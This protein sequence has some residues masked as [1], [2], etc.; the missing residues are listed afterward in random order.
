MNLKRAL[1]FTRISELPK[2]TALTALRN[3]EDAEAKADEQKAHER[4]HDP[5]VSE[6]GSAADGSRHPP[7]EDDDPDS[8]AAFVLVTSPSTTMK[9]SR[10]HDR[11]GNGDWY[12]TQHD[13][14]SLKH[15]A[16]QVRLDPPS[17]SDFA[18]SPPDLDAYSSEVSPSPSPLP[19]PIL[20][21]TSSPQLPESPE[22]L[23]DYDD[24]TTDEE[25]DDEGFGSDDSDPEDE[26]GGMAIRTPHLSSK[27]R[28][29]TSTSSSSNNRIRGDSGRVISANRRKGSNGIL[30]SLVGGGSRGIAR[31]A[32]TGTAQASTHSRVRQVRTTGTTALSSSRGGSSNK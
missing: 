29:P 2:M 24:F 19:S 14:A 25:D 9:D 23:S 22:S 1:S 15:R 7:D 4:A 27:L 13:V 11:H 12:D 5:T 6:R 26:T 28:R 18:S 3:R 20:M 21:Q 10:N 8:E 30:S 31:K 16:D 32:G 17:H